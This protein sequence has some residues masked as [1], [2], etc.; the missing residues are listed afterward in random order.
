MDGVVQSV[1]IGTVGGVVTPSESLVV[2]VP[3]DTPLIVEATLSNEEVGF[4]HLGQRVDIKIDSYPFQK[5]GSLG[6]TLVWISP[7]A[8][9]TQMASNTP[10]S[11]SLK[12]TQ[13]GSGREKIS[14][15]I[16]VRPDAQ[17][18][19]G[20]GRELALAPGMTLEA[21]IITEKRRVIDFFLSPIN[22][23]ISTGMKVR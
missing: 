13:A 5:F 11:G 6:G 19:K 15:K 12:T 20:D 21:D 16:H 22:K 3:K 18:L 14:Y 23:Y 2:I 9:E 4:V 8:E 17:F 1:N 10:D 7:D